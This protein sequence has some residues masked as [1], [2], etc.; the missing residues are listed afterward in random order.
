MAYVDT[1]Q[2]NEGKVSQQSKN[3]VSTLK[4]E[5]DMRW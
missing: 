1:S 5:I 3:Y 4:Y 2:M